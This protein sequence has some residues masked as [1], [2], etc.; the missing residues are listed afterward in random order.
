MGLYRVPVIGPSGEELPEPEIV[1]EV[2][3]C[4]VSGHTVDHLRERALVH[5]KNPL[6]AK[7]E[8]YKEG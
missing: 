6:E 5:L 3:N 1:D 8:N 2:G 4:G 7:L